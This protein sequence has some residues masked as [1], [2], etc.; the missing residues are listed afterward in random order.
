VIGQ[1][2]KPWDLDQITDP[3]FP[4]NDLDPRSQILDFQKSI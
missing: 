3:C 1:I 4:K 2:P